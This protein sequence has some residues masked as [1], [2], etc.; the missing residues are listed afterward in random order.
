M[1]Q[2]ARSQ[3]TQPREAFA[4]LYPEILK[5]LPM[6]VAVLHLENPRDPKTFKIIDVNPA[7][8]RLAGTAVNDLLGR[9]LGEFPE[10]LKTPLA[11]SC[12]DAYRAREARNLGEIAYGDKRVRQGIYSLQVFPLSGDFL[13]VVFENITDRKRSEQAMRESEERFRLLI[14]GVQEYALF[15]LDPLG[16]VVSWNA[17]AER[18]KG[19]R[20]E[21]ILGK[22]FSVFYP[23]E[24][25]LD[26]K[27]QRSLEEAVKRGQFEDEGWR[28]RKDG[29]RFWANAVVTALRT[30]EGN[31]RGFAKLTRD[32]SE[33]REREEALRKA[34][35]L[36]ELRVEQRA[37]V[38]SRV[39]EELRVEIS[40][41]RK[42]EEQFKE[43]VDQLRALAARLQNVREEERTAIAR[44]IHDELGQ[45]CTAIKMDL[46]LIG[47]KMTKRQTQLRARINSTTGL[48]D[49]MIAT[50]RRI[51]SDL[52]PRTLDDLG[53]AAALEWQAQD[54]E[55]RTG[56]RCRVT[57]PRETVALDAERSTAVFRIFQESLTNI[58]RHARAARVAAKLEI[59][60]D[61]LHFSVHDNGKGFD[62][63]EAKMRKSL[64]LV[65]MQ[66]RALLLNGEFKIEGTPEGG[67][68]VNL[69]IPLISSATPGLGSG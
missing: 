29:S 35:E 53:L 13:G 18:V 36:L 68:T 6:G 64:G 28:V 33:R 66:E 9:K 39:N 34:K 42:A 59:R 69:R 14:Q 1:A 25:L 49:E 60:D 61:Q 45:A 26:G 40:E 50:L 23:E 56:I 11:E 21:E 48:V 44:E 16:H 2:A 51:A 67:T 58:A 63:V 62:P 38:L 65:G 27:P 32:M 12:L 8:V 24:D 47:R 52:R 37:V 3:L 41:R 5:G 31:L 54:F 7:A 22:H 43:S 55:N 19:Y 10:L 17:G 30:S 4:F 57:L 20:K 46:A 15:Q